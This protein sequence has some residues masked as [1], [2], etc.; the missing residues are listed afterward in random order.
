M[1]IQEGIRARLLADISHELK[2]PITS[3]QCYLE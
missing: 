3:I 1:N 2:T